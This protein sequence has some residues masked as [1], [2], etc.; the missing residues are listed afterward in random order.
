MVV[1]PKLLYPK[2][3]AVT[4]IGADVTSRPCA[5]TLTLRNRA[6]AGSVSVHI[7]PSTICR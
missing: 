4:A 1:V 2:G 7:V 5:P 3:Y 6:G